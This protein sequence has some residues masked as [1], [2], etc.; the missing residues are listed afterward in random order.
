MEKDAEYNQDL[1]NRILKIVE[2]IVKQRNRPCLQ[3][4]NTFL[5]RGGVEINS[6]DLKEFIDVLVMRDILINIGDNETESFRL[7]NI[8]PVDEIESPRLGRP[9]S[10]E[11]DVVVEKITEADDVFANDKCSST[12]SEIEQI[13]DIEGFLF[14]TP[15]TNFSNGNMNST[16]FETLME[17]IKVEIT[18]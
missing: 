4:I 14:T 10:I 15:F 3:N 7:G 11:N 1:E 13:K 18:T 8:P 5:I 2:K 16:F 17:R 9:P 12:N 6:S